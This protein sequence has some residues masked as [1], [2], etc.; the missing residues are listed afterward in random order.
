M[1]RETVGLVL[2]TN[3]LNLAKVA[4][5]R[6]SGKD[7]VVDS[8]GIKLVIGTRRGEGVFCALKGRQY[9]EIIRFLRIAQHINAGSL[10]LDVGA[11]IGTYAVRVAKQN[12]SLRVVAIEA[13]PWNRA[14][15]R[16]SAEL[17][18]C[19]VETPE[20]GI[21]DVE[22]TCTV[23]LQSQG[24]ASVRAPQPIGSVTFPT[25]TIDHLAKL[26][27]STPLRL[28]KIDVD[29]M[30][31]QALQGGITTLS[32]C[33]TVIYFE[34]DA[35]VAN[36]LRGLGYVVGSWGTDQFKETDEGWALWALPPSFVASAQGLV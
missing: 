18:R 26:Y 10:F 35:G 8:G 2:K 29:G 19:A 23:P 12:P 31:Q 6:L 16:R 4:A 21:S 30:C 17:N 15:I 27:E 1:T 20:C 22:G 7:A 24:R 5:A 25:V 36:F 33:Q 34:N 11:N 14:R 13:L 3:P 28:L 32:Q 9:E